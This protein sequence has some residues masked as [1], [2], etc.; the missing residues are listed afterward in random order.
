MREILLKSASATI[1]IFV[2]E[3]KYHHWNDHLDAYYVM[4]DL[5]DAYIAN[6]VQEITSGM[7]DPSAVLREIGIS[8]EDFVAD[9][10]GAED[11]GFRM[12][13]ILTLATL[14]HQRLW[15]EI[16]TYDGCVSERFSEDV[17]K[18]AL[19]YSRIAIQYCDCHR[20]CYESEQVRGMLIQNI[21][22]LLVMATT[23]GIRRLA[24]MNQSDD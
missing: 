2:L 9:R 8:I 11:F 6:H 19:T 14:F 13:A 4:V 1:L 24:V 22:S 16:E 18:Q 17:R 20:G 12:S 7:T 10:H 21:Y 23:D 5:S 15:Q 3:K